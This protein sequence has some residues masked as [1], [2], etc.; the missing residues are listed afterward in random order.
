MV[1]YLLIAISLGNLG[2][3]AWMMVD[4]SGVIE[5]MMRIQESDPYTGAFSPASLGEFRAYSGLIMMLGVVTLRA[6]WNPI[7]AAWLQPLAW[8][9]LGISLARMSSLILDGEFSR[10]TFVT[11]LVEAT[12]AFLLGVHAQRMQ[13]ELEQEELE[14]FEE[15]DEEYE[16]DTA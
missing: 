3:G 7:Y 16:E 5:W 12:V 4:P 6:L 14:D 1:R 15:M 9:F 8:C 10:Y 11:G 2:F 13:Q